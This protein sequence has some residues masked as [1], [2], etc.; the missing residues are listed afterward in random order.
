MTP[1]WIE[2]RD[3]FDPA[4]VGTLIVSERKDGSKTVIDGQTRLRAMRDV[5]VEAAPCL[6]YVGLTRGQEAE[7]FAALQKQRRAMRTYHRF[8][9]ELVAGKEQAVGISKV[10]KDVGFELGREEKRN[11]LQS[12]TAL[13][14]T[15][16]VDPEHLAETLKVIRDAWAIWNEAGT[17]FTIDE[18]AVSAQIIN[19]VS[20]F[21]RKQERLD[22][23]RLVDRLQD[24]TP[25]MLINKSAQIRE[26]AGT[27]LGGAGA[28][29]QAILNEYM[30]NKRKV[31]DA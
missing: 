23:D 7:L 10:A 12:I 31:K 27:G 4:L 11:T 2:V 14:K 26:A 28:I 17:K 13:E 30:R 1:F 8:R 25:R 9:A 22:I 15:Y 16:R 29:A 19:G 21:I 3:N 18:D 24:V 6:V 5:E 20:T